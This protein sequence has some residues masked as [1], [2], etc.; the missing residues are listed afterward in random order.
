VPATPLAEPTA[1]DAV[2]AAVGEQLR[3]TV[4]S[5]PGEQVYQLP[6][7]DLLPTGPAPKTRSSANDAMIESITGC[8][9]SSRSRPRSP[10]SPAARRSPATRSSWARR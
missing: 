4:Q 8:S 10:A 9:T 2:D 1:D 3:L 7:S 5:G 6:P